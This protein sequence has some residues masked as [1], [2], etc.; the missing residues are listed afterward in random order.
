[1]RSQER[2]PAERLEPVPDQLESAQA[3]L[4]YVYLETTGGATVD[5]LG[6]ALSLKKIDVLS[7]LHSLTSR[8]LLEK[9]GTTYVVAD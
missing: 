1:M 3:K 4:V 2:V 6:R 5:E 9:D 8:G 7:V